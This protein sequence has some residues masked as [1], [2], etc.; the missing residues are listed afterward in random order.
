MAPR[1]AASILSNILKDSPGGRGPWSSR[2]FHVDPRVV[3]RPLANPDTELG[4][5]FPPSRDRGGVIAWG[6]GGGGGGGGRRCPSPPAF[7]RNASPL[8]CRGGC[9]RRDGPVYTK[10]LMLLGRSRFVR[11]ITERV[12]ACRKLSQQLCRCRRSSEHLTSLLSAEHAPPSVAGADVLLHRRY[13]RQSGG[14]HAVLQRVEQRRALQRG[15]HDPLA[16]TSTSTGLA[17]A[18]RTDGNVMLTITADTSVAT[19]AGRRVSAEQ[20]REVFARE[21][22]HA[23]LPR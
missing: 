6:G 4:Q 2:R 16:R 7:P 8:R 13:R 23:Q 1:T 12:M 17:A 11:P 22:A 9:L 21:A 15:G 20:H 10:K 14:R 18:A 5:F 19:T 3:P